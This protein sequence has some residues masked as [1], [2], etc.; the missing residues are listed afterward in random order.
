MSLQEARRNN[1]TPRLSLSEDIYLEERARAE[2][3]DA[4]QL[5]F[6]A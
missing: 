3:L 4:N 5:Q 1:D 2:A 6:G